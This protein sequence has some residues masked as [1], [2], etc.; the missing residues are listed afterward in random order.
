MAL[1]PMDIHNKEFSVKMRG[2]DQ[3]Q[4]ND[5]LDQIIKDY[6]LLL[7]QKKETEKKLEFAEEKLASYDQMQDS[8]NKSIIVAQDAADRLKE[9]AER[10]AEMISKEAENKASN[11]RQDAENHAD[12]LLKEAVGKARKIEEETEALRK[13]SR[14]FRQRL[15]L[16]IES[17]LEL[18]KKE[19]WDDLL[20]PPAS[21]KPVTNTINEVKSEL[22]QKDEVAEVPADSDPVDDNSE[23]YEEGMTP[24]VELPN[25]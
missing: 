21:E 12:Q 17:Q 3:D 15:Q 1:T 5:Y 6:E 24:A 18:V 4:V 25:V 8:L 13:Q 7:K 10:E 9:N 23:G 20:Q 16:M 14:I 11:V 19:E 2:Y 22:E